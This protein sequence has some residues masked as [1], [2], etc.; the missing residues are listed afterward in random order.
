MYL[1]LLPT[2]KVI[3]TAAAVPRDLSSL[4]RE[5]PTAT[6]L[7]LFWT[8]APVK[9]LGCSRIALRGWGVEILVERVPSSLQQS[10]RSSLGKAFPAGVGCRAPS[11]V[12]G[13]RGG[14]R[15]LVTSAPQ[16]R[17]FRRS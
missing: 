8:V 6:N 14:G 15:Y 11:A 16:C 5:T 2:G 13:L 12:L 7:T 9:M 4:S 1:R 3:Q 17:T 10:H